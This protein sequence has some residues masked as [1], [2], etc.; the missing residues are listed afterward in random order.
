MLIQKIDTDFILIIY[1]NI[2]D[3]CQIFCNDT[4][5]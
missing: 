3:V 4:H 1:Q 5:Q 2:H